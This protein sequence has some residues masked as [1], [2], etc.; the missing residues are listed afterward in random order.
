MLRVQLISILLPPFNQGHEYMVGKW[1]FPL[2][3]KQSVHFKSSLPSLSLS[4]KSL[5]SFLSSPSAFFPL[6]QQGLY[7]LT[8]R[9]SF[10]L[11]GFL[12][13]LLLLH[14]NF[15]F[16]FVS[17]SLKSTSLVFFFKESLIS[18]NNPSSFVSHLMSFPLQHTHTH[19]P[20]KK[21]RC[22]LQI[23]GI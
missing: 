17:E 2:P 19:K 13:F 20:E 23:L 22:W 5:S 9:A 18:W 1:L 16:T 12:F 3:W 8:S 6:S 4:V 11:P 21:Q 10:F 14:L 15:L 7:W